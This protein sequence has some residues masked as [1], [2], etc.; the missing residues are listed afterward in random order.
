LPPPIIPR[1]RLSAVALALAVVPAAPAR[2]QVPP[3]TLL[4]V[5]FENARSEPRYQWLS[6]ASAVLVT[7]GLRARS[8]PAITRLERVSAFEEL[9]LPVSGLLTRATVIKVGQ[10]LGV[11]EVVVGSFTVEGDQLSVSA[12]VIHV[13]VG[14]VDAPAAERGPLTEL[15]AV[16]DRL[17]R[18]LAKD[19]PLAPAA[20]IEQPPLD[21]FESFIK[22]LLAE[23]PGTRAVFLESAIREQT[24][25]DRA[26][27][28]LWE[29]RTDQGDHE[30]AL[31]TV[32]AIQ[33]TSP[34]SYRARFAAAVSLL[35]LERYDE[36]FDAFK[37]LL[38]SKGDP[39]STAAVLNNLG[40]VQIRRG[41]S[42]QSGTATYYFT[43]AADADSDPDYLFNLGYAYVLER[44]HQGALYWLREALRRDPTD[45][46]AH[47]VLAAA[48]QGTASATESARERDLARQLSARYEVLDKQSADTSQVPSG[49]ERV[50]LEEEAARVLRADQA[51]ISSAQREHTELAEFH[52]ERG[53]RLFEKEQ[54]REAM[55]ELRRAV[56]LSPYEAEAHLLIGRIH[57]RA[58]QAGDAIDALKISIW[59]QETPAA[60]LALTEAYL[61]SGNSALAK[62][63]AE[64]ALVL[65]P[66]SAEAKRLLATIK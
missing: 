49:L 17:A 23:N 13:D 29:V 20:K 1:F 45:A 32:R 37:A 50:A 31:A 47:F 61:K 12:Q 18:R 43:K 9:H 7:D 56:Y 42:P 44:N 57:L 27:L 2:A 21:A 3:A 63:E 53:R 52:L 14:R 65:D 19:A 35:E 30:S 55:A 11:R 34:F 5:P 54:D 6:E 10:L 15:F 58:G 62:A 26:R 48:L 22:G 25:F 51:I 33:S 40:V 8:V 60:R 59:S 39:L 64:R 41:G 24:D 46:D 66:S 38:D 4:V 36:A 28:A 16:Y